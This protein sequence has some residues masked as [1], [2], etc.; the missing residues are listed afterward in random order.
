M[1]KTKRDIQCIWDGT[2]VGYI[3]KNEAATTE[4]TTK[5]IALHGLLDNLNSMLPL[6][7]KLINRHPSNSS[8]LLNERIIFIFCYRL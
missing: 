1:I 8:Y 4:I 7:E 3:V 2:L 5:I 6:V